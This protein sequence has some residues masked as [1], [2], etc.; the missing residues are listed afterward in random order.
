MGGSMP[1]DKTKVYRIIGS[2]S[3]IVVGG[4]DRAKDRFDAMRRHE[5]VYQ[6]LLSPDKR[7]FQSP[8]QQSQV[9]ALQKAIVN[10]FATEKE[11]QMIKDLFTSNGK[12]WNGDIGMLQEMFRADLSNKNDYPGSMTATY[13]K[14]AL[15]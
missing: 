13:S 5:N 6:G 1:E 12:Y 14:D 7:V 2:D 4:N 10:G 3:N 9:I 8:L 11:E 15:K